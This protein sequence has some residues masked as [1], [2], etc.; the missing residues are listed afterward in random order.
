MVRAKSICATCN[1]EFSNHT[2]SLKTGC[3]LVWSSGDLLSHAELGNMDV[4]CC[5]K[6]CWPVTEVSCRAQPSYFRSCYLKALVAVTLTTRLLFETVNET[7]DT[8]SDACWT[9]TVPA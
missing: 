2:A 7:G 4:A 1:E 6:M 5:C 8:A 9:V 3:N